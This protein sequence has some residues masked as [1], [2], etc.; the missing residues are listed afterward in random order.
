MPTDN[1]AGTESGALAPLLRAVVEALGGSVVV[2]DRESRVVFAT[3]GARSVLDPLARKGETGARL[4]QELAERGGR[5][6]PL[7]LA[8]YTLGEAVFLPAAEATTLAERE[9]LAILSTLRS[10]QWRLTE[11]ARHL[12]ISRTTLWRR[13]KAYGVRR[14]D[15]WSR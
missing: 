5:R 8:G 4:M 14:D 2:F 15:G 11:A 1:E 6:V 9:R 3:P 12:G 13:L 7:R 10:T